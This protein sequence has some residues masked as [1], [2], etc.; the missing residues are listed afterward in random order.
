MEWLVSEHI[1]TLMEG[2]GFESLK[3]SMF[4]GGLAIVGFLLLLV[5]FKALWFL[6]LAFFLAAAG[7]FGFL[8]YGFRRLDRSRNKEQ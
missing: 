6:D 3:S 2:A 7:F 1:Q 8:E 4:L 5:I